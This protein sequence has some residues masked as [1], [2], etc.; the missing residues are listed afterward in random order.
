MLES[1]SERRLRDRLPQVGRVQWI[2]RAAERKGPI[3]EVEEVRMEP[4]TG[5][6]GDHH[7]TGRRAGSRRQVTLIQAEHLPVIAALTDHD[8]IPPAWL[9]RNIVVSGIPLLALLK[10]RF[11]L[12]EA[13]L[14]TTGLCDPCDRMEHTL[15]AGGFNAM[16]G[17]GGITARVIEGGRVKIG[18]EVRLILNS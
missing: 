9:R 8:Q 16:Q 17:H 7:A 5:I 14:E 18:D 15:G 10:K 13:L 4:S 6:E 1:K 11:R 12:G 2:G 3:E